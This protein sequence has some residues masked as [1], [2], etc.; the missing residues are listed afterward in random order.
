MTRTALSLSPLFRTTVGFDKFD[1][2]FNSVL[3]GD[4]QTKNLSYPPY[5]IE[6]HGEDNYAITMAVAGFGENDIS[7]S[8]QNGQLVIEGKIVEEND[9][10]GKEYLHKGI[11]ARAFERSFK[12]ADHMV[13]TDAELKNGLLKISLVREVPEEKKPRLIPINSSKKLENKKS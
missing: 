4:E 12:L 8:T 3:N 13:V 11:A 10:E 9:Q 7:V 2:L 5:N 6:K 1:E